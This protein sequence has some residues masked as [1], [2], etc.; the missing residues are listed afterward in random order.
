MGTAKVSAQKK[1]NYNIDFIYGILYVYALDILKHI[2]TY[3]GYSNGYWTYW[4][5]NGYSILC[6][7]YHGIICR[8][9]IMYFITCICTVSIAILLAAC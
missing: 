6:G 1:E 9:L 4:T 5:Y 3:N 2:A 7:L 8:L